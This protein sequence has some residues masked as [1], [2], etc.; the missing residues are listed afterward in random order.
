ML[1]L[2]N[3]CTKW[4]IAFFDEC[5][6][7]LLSP[8]LKGRV[9][10][11]LSFFMHSWQK[12]S[13]NH[14]AGGWCWCWKLLWVGVG[15][16]ISLLVVCSCWRRSCSSWPWLQYETIQRI[17]QLCKCLLQWAVSM[18]ELTQARSNTNASSSTSMCAQ[19]FCKQCFCNY[20]K[21]HLSRMNKIFSYVFQIISEAI[22]WY[23]LT[24]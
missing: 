15:K 13:C 19:P 12:C 17:M 6:V 24:S 7:H 14:H 1:T 4:S 23:K 20:K 21:N 3:Y 9:K 11:A 8:C 22:F 18:K 10:G 16:K 5:L 2:D